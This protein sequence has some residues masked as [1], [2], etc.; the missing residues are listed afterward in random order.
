[1]GEV[2]TT[3]SWF[4]LVTA[5]MD[6]PTPKPPQGFLEDSVWCISFFHLSQRQTVVQLD[7][8]PAVS[9]LF[10]ALWPIVLA[11]LSLQR[12]CSIMV[13][14]LALSMRLLPF[15]P[16]TT[17]WPCGPGQVHQLAK[18]WFPYLQAWPKN[19]TYFIGLL[20]RLQEDM[21]IEC[22][23]HSQHL[24]SNCLP[25]THGEMPW[26]GNQHCWMH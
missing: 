23:R 25:T 5:L 16:F 12:K 24:G 11:P 13:K 4:T 14:I 10:L 3:V 20:W 2:L 7:A 26:L 18:P 9:P 22:F 19:G 15:I 6:S 1:M 8:F 17:Y 21:Q